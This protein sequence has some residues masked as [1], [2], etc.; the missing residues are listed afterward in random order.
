MKA[1]KILRAVFLSLLTILLVY[2]GH[3]KPSEVP[4][5]KSYLSPALSAI[6]PVGKLFDPFRGF[7]ANAEPKNFPSELSLQADGLQAP[8]EVLFD[9]RLVPHVFA[10]N[11]QDL[12]FAQGYLTA[13][14]RLWQMEFQ[15]H[16]AAGRISEI[17]GERALDLD[18]YQRGLGMVYGAEQSLETIMKDSTMKN[19]IEAYTQGVNAY[20]EQLSPQDYPLEYKIL[21]YA[22]EPWT[23]LKSAL[24][25]KYMAYDLSASGTDDLAMSHALAKFGKPVLDSIFPNYSYFSSPIIPTGTKLDFKPQKNPPVP[26]NA[27]AVMNEIAKKLQKEYEASE[28]AP[29]NKGSNNWA[30]GA[31]KTASGYPILA[32][33][34]HLAL[35]LPSIWYEMQLVSPSVN[36]YGVTIPGAPMVVIGFNSNISWG[37]TNT[38]TDVM[39]FYQIKFRDDKMEEYFHDGQW[40]KVSIRE[41]PIKIRGKKEVSHQVRYTHHGPV[42]FDREAKPMG[43]DIPAGHALKWLAL[44]GSN[45]MLTFYKLNRA[46]NYEA[47]LDA[48]RY[49]ICP[50]QNF[51]YADVEK[52]IA[53]WV[54]GK[55]P[56]RWKEQGKYVLDGSNSQ[57]EWQGFL[58]FEHNPHVKNPDRHFVSS[59]NQFATDTISYP[60]YLNWNYSSSER[61]MRINEVLGGLNKITLDDIQA[62]QNDNTNLLAREVMPALLARLRPDTTQENVRKVLGRFPK[63]DFKNAPEA[64]SATVFE[65]WWRQLEKAI[66]RDELPSPMRIP[67]TYI[68]YQILTKDTSAR[69]FDNIRT[70]AKED[71]NTII[72]QSFQET[73]AMLEKKHGPVGEAWQWGKHKNTSIKHL[74]QI[75][76]MG[77]EGLMIGGGSR[78]VNATTSTHGPSWR[79][80]V[81]M[82]ERV[83]AYGIYPGGQSGN[84]GSPYYA[85]MVERWRL[86]ELAE[87]LYLKDASFKSPRIVSKLSFEK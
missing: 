38:Y 74:A 52:N 23:A 45:E 2:I 66:W 50:G 55:I 77:I 16:F 3:H 14:F 51:A 29:R 7:W 72:N 28:A 22:P 73:M 11:D 25:L 68:T 26:A 6:P 53:L 83:K 9:D 39:D 75:P 46:K 31:R 56:F 65:E 67:E 8:V 84:P 59:A 47:F 82:E 36:V 78:I 80:V 27:E 76:G 48:I 58:P 4:L 40:K 10:Q 81:L 86:G 49:F 85:D 79:M 32:N 5:L 70:A 61:G 19:V 43:V 30:V 63:W 12:Y 42:V 15:T 33:D 21:D 44:E 34:P 69:W 13:Q 41:E 1:F 35:R 64:I 24:I 18:R 37:V 57:H 17:V 20:I 62:L 71:I 87:L 54:S 60:Y